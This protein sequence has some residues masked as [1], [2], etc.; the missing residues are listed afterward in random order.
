[1]APIRREVRLHVPADEAWAVLGDPQRRA[2]YD[3]RRTGAT[4][5]GRASAVR[6]RDDSFVFVPLAELIVTN[7]PILRRFQYR[8]TG[9]VVR[10]HLG[11]IDV[12]DLH[13]DSCLVVYSTD[14]E[15]DVMALVIGGATGNALH[16]LQRQLE[17]DTGGAS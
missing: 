10:H 17:S 11:T 15:P 1:M 8:I 13:D 7:D 5:D 16:E 4:V 6:R 3:A 14:A 12:I 2:A 9:G